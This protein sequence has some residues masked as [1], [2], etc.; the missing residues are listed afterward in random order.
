M[1]RNRIGDVDIDLKAPYWSD[2]RN[3]AQLRKSQILYFAKID[4]ANSEAELT[5]AEVNKQDFYN[6]MDLS[7][8]II[9]LI[10]AYGQNE[11]L[12]LKAGIVLSHYIADGEFGIYYDS[13]ELRNADLSNKIR[14]IQKDVENFQEWDFANDE[15][16]DEWEHNVMDMNYYCN[17]LTGERSNNII[18]DY[19]NVCGPYDYA[20]Y[21]SEIKK[22]GEHWL[23]M[24][25]NNLQN[26][27]GEILS[28]VYKK[29]MLQIRQASWFESANT[30]LSK[31]AIYSL[32]RSK[33]CE[34]G[35]TPE[36]AIEVL[37][38]SNGSKEKLENELKKAGIG[39]IGEPASATAVA[40][41][42]VTLIKG[43][44]G[45][46]A[47]LATLALAVWAIVDRVKALLDKSNKN[48]YEN[49]PSAEDL[50]M[51]TSTIEDWENFLEE[52]ENPVEN[53]MANV[54]DGTKSLFRSPIA[55][56]VGGGALLLLLTRK[57]G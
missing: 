17:P 25:A 41:G 7:F 13:M 1:K 33:I 49:A 39:R 54:V 57:R 14:N 29:R 2:N 23:Y 37:K 26:D 35:Y 20:Y 32:S 31:E 43:I 15:F 52:Q 46:L 3:D 47:G 12:L 22:N 4:C 16:A 30:N 55:W 11:D 36:K 34:R 42:I 24:S 48:A 8:C 18:A 19:A 44:I 21:S 56:I 50:K 51:A 6:Q 28:A 38:F 5:N 27:K 45:L 53:F 40:I 9:R 10:D